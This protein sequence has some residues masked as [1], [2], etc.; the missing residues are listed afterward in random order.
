MNADAQPATQT[1]GEYRYEKE[2]Y[3]G[4]AYYAG[5]IVLCAKHAQVGPLLEALEDVMKLVEDGALVRDISRDHEMGW[6][7]NQV[8]L[9]TALKSATVAIAA[10]RPKLA[11]AKGG[12]E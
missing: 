4:G 8:P 10:A 12:A 3:L 2:Y 9:V 7:F 11:A 6:A 1:C 5:R